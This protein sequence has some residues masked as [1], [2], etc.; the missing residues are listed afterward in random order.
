MPAPFMLIFLKLK[1]INILSTV[2]EM[3]CC[4]G[5]LY[6]IKSE[7]K[8]EDFYANFNLLILLKD[9]PTGEYPVDIY[10]FYG[11]FNHGL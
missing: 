7:H 9:Q 2:A 1:Q 4:H 8:F 10:A 3:L 5:N 11:I 6:C